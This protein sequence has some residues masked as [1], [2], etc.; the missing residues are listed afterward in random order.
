MCNNFHS[1]F[2]YIIITFVNN[3]RAK[4][5][6]IKRRERSDLKICVDLRTI[7]ALFMRKR[8]QRKNMYF[9][10]LLIIFY[11]RAHRTR[12]RYPFNDDQQIPANNSTAIIGH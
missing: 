8:I 3:A 7:L 11:T 2:R 9:S 5:F 4:K 6:N 1:K 10:F 12:K